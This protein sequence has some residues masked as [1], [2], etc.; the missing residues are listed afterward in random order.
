MRGVQEAWGY[1]SH[2]S[3]YKRSLIHQRRDLSPWP[4]HLGI[5][6][7]DCYYGEKLMA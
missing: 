4:L 6:E 3:C 7:K 1:E 2:S 5:R